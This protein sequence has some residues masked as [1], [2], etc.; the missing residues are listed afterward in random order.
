MASAAEIVA[1]I[2]EAILGWVGT[3]ASITINGRVVTYRKLQDL[4]DART[5]YQTLQSQQSSSSFPFGVTKV[6][7]MASGGGS[8]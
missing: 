1:A 8:G 2:D 6:T 5:Y 3:P 7:P 4:L